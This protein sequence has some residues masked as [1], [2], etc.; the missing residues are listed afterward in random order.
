MSVGYNF[1]GFTDDDFVAA[2]YTAQGP[3]LKFRMKLDQDMF[4]R[5]LSFA[6]W[7]RQPDAGEGLAGP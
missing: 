1:V 5:F 2:D 7:R 3:Y 6:G 4:R